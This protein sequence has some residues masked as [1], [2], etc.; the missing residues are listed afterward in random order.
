V[1]GPAAAVE[2][3]RRAVRHVNRSHQALSQD[4]YA[5]TA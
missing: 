3:V 1:S 4:R 2:A 5:L